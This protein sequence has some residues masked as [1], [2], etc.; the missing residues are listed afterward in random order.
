M[1]GAEALIRWN[2]PELGEILPEVFIPI[3]E[4]SGLIIDIGAWVL[5]EACAQASCWRRDG[6]NNLRV[7]VN[8]SPVQFRRGDIER[9]V[10]GALEASGLPGAALELELTESL[11]IDESLDLSAVLHGLSNRGVSFS[12][13]DFGSGY[14]NL[15][16]LKRFE[17]E[18]LKIDQGFTRGLTENPDNEAIVQAI[19]QMAHSLKL[20]VVA[21]GIEESQT[22]QRLIGLGCDRGQGFYWAPAIP[23]EAFSQWLGKQTVSG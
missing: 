13:D 20:L 12:I 10:L 23:A 16:Y 4:R 11:F 8:V 22:L 3:A 18:V 17:V 9:V 19:T 1:V 14:S 6:F 21:E 2:H 15:G 5:Q 7:S